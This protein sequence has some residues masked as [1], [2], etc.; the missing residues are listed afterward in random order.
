MAAMMSVG[1]NE[2]V[3]N[4]LGKTQALGAVAIVVESV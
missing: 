4:E 3:R 2:T 1:G